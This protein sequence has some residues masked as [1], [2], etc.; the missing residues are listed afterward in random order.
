MSGLPGT[1]QSSVLLMK[2]FRS[3]W[4]EQTEP[5]PILETNK[6]RRGQQRSLPMLYFYYV[7][8]ECLHFI[9]LGHGHTGHD[10]GRN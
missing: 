5:E 6:K 10:A 1:S 4:M 3:D 9:R 8:F 7:T 2:S